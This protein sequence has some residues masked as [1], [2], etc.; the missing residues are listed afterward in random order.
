M[1]GLASGSIWSVRQAFHGRVLFRYALRAEQSQQGVPHRRVPQ[2]HMR[3]RR[4][5]GGTVVLCAL[6]AAARCVAVHH[7]RIDLNT[8]VGVGKFKY[9]LKTK[10]AL[11]SPAVLGR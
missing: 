2:W 8:Q 11:F 7:S 5:H 6:Q 9:L 1:P 3:G 4:H 10:T